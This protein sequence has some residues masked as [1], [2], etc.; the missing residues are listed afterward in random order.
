MGKAF[1]KCIHV[2]TI[3]LMVHLLSL[4]IVCDKGVIYCDINK[5]NLNQWPFL[6]ECLTGCFI[7][8][9]LSS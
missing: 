8:P 1:M 6:S 7:I 4:L 9:L 5:V 2:K 3:P